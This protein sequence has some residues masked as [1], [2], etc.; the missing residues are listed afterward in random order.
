MYMYNFIVAKSNV[1]FCGSL[2]RI[3]SF[4]S[5][6]GCTHRVVWGSDSVRLSSPTV[7]E[8]EEVMTKLMMQNRTDIQWWI[9]LYTLSSDCLLT[10]FTKLNECVVVRLDI[11]DTQFDSHCISEL[12]QVLTNN[13]TIEGLSFWSSPLTSTGLELLSNA[14][15]VNS[16]LKALILVSDNTIT[17]EEIPYII[18]MLSTLEVLL[19]NFCPS[20]TNN[21]MQHISQVATTNTSLAQVYINGCDLCICY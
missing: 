16:T 1:S 11:N 18:N 20:I 7:I 14:V 6:I 19:I 9:E 10:V 8:C 5:I 12:C 2:V 4:C 3:Y 21:G 15:S 13:K 17:D